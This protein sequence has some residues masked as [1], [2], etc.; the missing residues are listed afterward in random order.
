MHNI[1]IEI[2]GKSYPLL[3]EQEEALLVLNLAEQINS[4]IKDLQRRYANKLNKQDIL[5]ILLFTY[6][7][8]F[9]DLENDSNNTKIEEKIDTLYLI[10]D[11]SLNTR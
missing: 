9:K 10:L 3:V 6:A 8:K 11:N 1:D 7:K 5:S 4:E 2:A